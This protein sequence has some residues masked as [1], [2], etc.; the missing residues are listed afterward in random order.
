LKERA[1]QRAQQ[2]GVRVLLTGGF[3]DE[4]YDRGDDWLNE[5]LA[6][7]R[8][9]DSVRELVLY[10]RYAGLRWT[11]EAGFLRRVLR[12]WLETITGGRYRHDP[13][14]PDWLTP[15]SQQYLNLSTQHTPYYE[16]YNNL[17]G[18]SWSAN[19]YA[20]ENFFASRHAVEIR[21][22]FHDRRLVEF[23]LALPAYQLY[24]RGRNKYIL[25][26]AM[27][28]LLPEKVRERSHPTPMMSFFFRGVNRENKFLQKQF[29][30]PD[31]HWQRF[32][33][34]NWVEKR[35]NTPVPPDQDGPHVIVPWLSFSYDSWYKK[36]HLFQTSSKEPKMSR[37]YAFLENAQNTAGAMKSAKSYRKPRLEKLGDLRALTL[38]GSPGINDTVNPGV[39]QAK[40]IPVGFPDPGFEQPGGGPPLP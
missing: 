37:N 14:G 1:Y 34:A 40:P 36:H 26:N 29:S 19:G 8:L 6:E 5:M 13:G 27:R 7:G 38:G 12:R 21:H 4:L 18:V 20:R 23:A 28:G 32:V 17:L 3:G 30:D 2:E 39:T 10:L 35:W 16:E 31:N 33:K 24:Y 22:P 11:L 15:T 25:R 9:T